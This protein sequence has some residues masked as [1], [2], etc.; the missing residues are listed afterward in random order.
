VQVNPQSGLIATSDC[1]VS[2]LSY[3]IKGTEPTEYCMAHLND[4]STEETA[5]EE[6][7]KEEA[8]K[9]WWKKF[10]PWM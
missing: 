2:R 10:V 5:P 7:P 4:G 1:P 8:P 6:S 9:K 3:Y